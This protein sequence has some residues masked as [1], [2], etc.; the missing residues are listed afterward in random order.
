MGHN[1]NFCIH[2]FDLLC[3]FGAWYEFT[4]P[5]ERWMVDVACVA[6]RHSS[7]F[8]TTNISGVTHVSFFRPGVDIE[9]QL[10]IHLD[11]LPESMRV[12][13]FRAGVSGM[14]GDRGKR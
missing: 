11:K 3:R 8:L 10:Q 9:K 13:G 14:Q 12:L 5:P 2:H 1:S 4:S 6:G 7:T